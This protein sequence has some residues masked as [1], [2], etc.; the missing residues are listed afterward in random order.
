MKRTLSVRFL[1]ASLALVVA[2]LPLVAYAH[3]GGT[4]QITGAEAGGYLLYVWSEPAGPR[5][6]D[7]VHI[8][9]G[10]T[11]PTDDA[12]AETPVTDAAVTIYFNPQSG[13]TPLELAASPGASAGAAYYEADTVVPTSG[14]WQVVVAVDG[15][16]GTGSADFVLPVGE[17][18]AT[19]YATMALGILIIVIGV[20]MFV[21]QNRRAKAR[22][23]EAI[24]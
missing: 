6:G 5:A 20:G 24:T 1:L 8:T 13:G 22:P 3:G 2:L 11:A 7:T 10:V 14:N 16:L 18:K 9:V 21:R 17:A 12:T 4:P 23:G 15:A 19:G